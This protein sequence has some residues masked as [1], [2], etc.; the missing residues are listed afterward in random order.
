MAKHGNYAFNGRIPKF[1]P[2]MYQLI[3]WLF[4]ALNVKVRKV[5]QA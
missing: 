5:A 4:Y 3:E 1:R 2:N